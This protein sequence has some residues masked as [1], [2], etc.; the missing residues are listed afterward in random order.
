MSQR[1]LFL[2]FAVVALI[3]AMAMASLAGARADRAA[4]VV[5]INGDNGDFHG[6]ITSPRNRC[7]GHR[8]VKVFKQKGD[9]QNPR[10][11]DVIGKDISER[12]NDAGLWS[13]GNTGFKHG[14]F[15]AKVKRNDLC[16]LDYSKTISL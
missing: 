6:R 3:G 1:K 7:L 15:Y 13:L 14:D 5:T 4:T 2:K 10:R 16:K 12:H 9:R 8:T 11:D